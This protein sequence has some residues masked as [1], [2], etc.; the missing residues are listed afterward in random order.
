MSKPN[1]P[2]PTAALAAALAL[3]ALAGCGRTEAPKVT[4]QPAVPVQI[5]V[6]TREDVPRRIESIG[7]VQALRT[8][9]IKS[10]VDGI[11]AEVR[12]RE[13]DDVKAGDL[14]VVLDRRPLEN[15]LRI[16][17]ADLVNARAEASKAD[18]DLERYKRLDQQDAISKEQFAQ[19]VTKA[20]TT[21]AFLQAKEAAVAN[22][23]LLFGYTEIRAPISGRA[24]QRLLHEG[25]LVKANDNAYSLVTINQLAPVAV[26]YSVPESSLDDIRRALAEQRARVS[27]VDRASG[28]AREDGKLAFID[29]AVDATTGMITLKAEF[30]NADKALWPGRFVNVT[31][32]VGLDV[33]ATVVPSTAVQT[34]QNGSTI[35]VVKADQTV[36]LR[37]VKVART[38]GDFSLIADGVKPGETVVTDGQLRL[39]P[40]SKIEAKTLAGGVAAADATQ[41]SKKSE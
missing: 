11:V 4:V 1:P 9:A 13:G 24:G 12:F 17:R 39:L 36:D 22:A 2:T 37:T 40:G 33:A 31:T 28:L 30:P 7:A 29:N 19:L 18:A 38:S 15:S 23:E 16:A 14:L 35:Y 8:V 3:F 5:A 26:A 32:Q 34:S 41:P 6:A 21:K 27:V 20:E 25:A 10:Q